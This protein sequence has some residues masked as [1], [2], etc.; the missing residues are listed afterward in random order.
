MREN[1]AASYQKAMWKVILIGLLP[2]FCFISLS[3][4]FAL[5]LSTVIHRVI[6][7]RESTKVAGAH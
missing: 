3:S 6:L 4:C 7:E 2:Q 1:F 5:S